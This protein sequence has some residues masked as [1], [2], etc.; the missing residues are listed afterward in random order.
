MFPH[1]H[2]SPQIYQISFRT[3]WLGMSLP[4][5]EHCWQLATGP[6]GS[7]ESLCSPCIEWLQ[8]QELN[9]A[10]DM[11]QSTLVTSPT[12]L[13]IAMSLGRSVLF[14]QHRCHSS[15]YLVRGPTHAIVAILRWRLWPFF[16]T[17]EITSTAD[18]RLI[19]ASSEPLVV[20]A[21]AD[22]V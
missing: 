9:T 7:R 18:G 16:M 19:L 2:T 22:C 17:S 8:R 12:F 1:S 20:E 15:S 5:Q 13:C 6:N 11:D 10:D 4:V 14:N 21:Q 3:L